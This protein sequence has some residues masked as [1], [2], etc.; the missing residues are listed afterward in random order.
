MAKRCLVIIM[1]GDGDDYWVYPGKR[2]VQENDKVLF[3]AVD[4]NATV[5][6]PG[7]KPLEGTKGFEL[8]DSDVKGFHV[9]MPHQSEPIMYE[10]H[11]DGKKAKGGS[12]PEMIIDP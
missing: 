12:D 1:K 6:F 9:T 8:K 3:E 10:V 7:K 11:C 2:H 5:T 4:C